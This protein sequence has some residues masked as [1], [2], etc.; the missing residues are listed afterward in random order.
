MAGDGAVGQGGGGE[1]VTP[2]EKRLERV[3]TPGAGENAW[4][5]GCATNCKAASV[6]VAQ[7][8]YDAA[9]SC[10]GNAHEHP[11]PGVF[12]FSTLFLY[13]CVLN[14]RCEGRVVE[15]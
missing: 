2:G 9:A 5:G 8:Q 6:G 3:E 11:H 10:P 12:A 15:C 1:N 7:S 13:G 14:D 4:S